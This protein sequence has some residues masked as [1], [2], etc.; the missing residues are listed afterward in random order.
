MP[1]KIHLL[2]MG[3]TPIFK[4]PYGGILLFKG[5]HGQGLLTVKLCCVDESTD[6]DNVTFCA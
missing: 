2:R 3:V 1:S 6:Q 4:T 5:R